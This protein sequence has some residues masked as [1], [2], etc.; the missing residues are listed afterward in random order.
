MT[1]IDKCLRLLL[2]GIASITPLFILSQNLVPNHD[3]S[4]VINCP[5]TSGQINI[6]S[7]HW[8]TP[9]R[10][11]TDIIHECGNITV[12]IPSNQWGTQEAFAGTGYAGIRTYLAPP[13]N[14]NKDYREYLAVKLISQLE[15]GAIY[16]VSFQA[17]PAEI[18]LYVTDDVGIYLG[19]TLVSDSLFT[20]KPAIRNK[21][22]SFLNNTKAWTRIEGVYR[23]KGHE[24][25]LVLGNFLR[26]EQT[27]LKQVGQV[28]VLEETTYLY[29]DDVKV[30]L[31][32]KGIPERLILAQDTMICQG[33]EITIQEVVPDSFSFEW[34]DGSILPERV[35]D[36]AGT[37]MLE[38]DINGCKIQDSI[39]IEDIIDSNLADVVDTVIC[40]G[41]VA[42]L[43][44]IDTSA[45]WSWEDSNQRDPVRN[46]S[47]TGMY[48]LQSIFSG[49]IRKDSVFIRVDSTGLLLQAL[50]SIQDTL[51]CGKEL[52]LEAPR[53]T[54]ADY[55]WSDQTADPQLVVS[56]KGIYDLMISTVCADVMLRYVIAESSCK[57]QFFAPNVIT[58]NGDGYN[59]QFTIEYGDDIEAVVLEIY[60]RWGKKIFQTRKTD[61]VW[62]VGN[63]VHAG[64]YFWKLKYHCKENQQKP[65]IYY[66]VINIFN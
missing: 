13:P 61:A 31:C 41:E 56:E 28:G 45:Q 44:V 54:D 43:R 53:L 1:V 3:F 57:C 7:P 19:D 52:L 39:K 22:G 46:I 50:P 59:D 47:E 6:V 24:R 37:Y 8:F 58:P 64:V 65:R 18:A 27:T 15:K 2:L 33:E 62:E 32:G 60:D 42:T 23:A 25:F 26:D 11:S 38:A 51:E 35:I 36:R 66:G 63:A 5:F 9:N 21:E 12:G 48:V 17:S 20:Y 55:L 14:S 34:G 4:E 29:I 16:R 30:E 49:C 10:L 40:P